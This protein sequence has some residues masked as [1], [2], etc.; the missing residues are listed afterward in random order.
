MSLLFGG[1]A[2]SGCDRLGPSSLLEILLFTPAMSVPH[3]DH[4][5]QNIIPCFLLHHHS[6]GK[7][8]AV[9]ADMAECFGEP[10]IRSVQPVTGMMG[11]IQFPIRIVWEAMMPRFVMRSGT[12]HGGV[13][14]GYVEVNRP[15]AE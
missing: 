1:A 13:I 2:G 8:A 11:N 9:P 7:H 10:A 12:L 4:G 3:G 15:R 5:R 6:I 14:L